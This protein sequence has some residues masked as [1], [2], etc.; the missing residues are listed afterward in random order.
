M[1]SLN[2][3]QPYRAMNAVSLT[4]RET[5]VLSLLVQGATSKEMAARLF[6]SKR[7][8]DFHLNNLYVKLDVNN[9]VSAMRV[10][11]RLGFVPVEPLIGFGGAAM[12]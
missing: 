11:I 9:R 1:E 4:E 10:A 3:S 5:E 8:I 7:T 2:F 6:V 12:R